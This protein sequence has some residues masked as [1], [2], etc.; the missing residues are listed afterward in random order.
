MYVWKAQITRTENALKY[1]QRNSKKVIFQTEFKSKDPIWLQKAS[2]QYNFY[3][4]KIRA[5]WTSAEFL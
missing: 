4:V 2:R 5:S 3:K 1:T